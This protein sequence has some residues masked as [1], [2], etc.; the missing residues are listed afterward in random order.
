MRR[1]DRPR[2]QARA[3]LAGDRSAKADQL[4][5]DDCRATDRLTVIHSL[6]RLVDVGDAKWQFTSNGDVQIALLS[7]E[8]FRLDTHELIRIR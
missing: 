1:N 6:Q 3:Q 7:G 8:T 5:S 2:R 4:R